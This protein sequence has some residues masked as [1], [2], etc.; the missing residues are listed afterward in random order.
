MCGDYYCS[1]NETTETCG[2][3]C[4]DKDRDHYAVDDPLCIS[5]DP[6]DPYS[7]QVDCNDN[8]SRIHPGA[9][10]YCNGIDNNCNGIVDDKPQSDYS[11]P[12]Y[13]YSDPFC[14]TNGEC[15]IVCLEGFADCDGLDE[16]GCE[17]Y[18]GDGSV[19]P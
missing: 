9:Y 19:C 13:Q 15:S 6:T 1:H 14:N 4:C 12:T 17:V 5:T 18:V 11:C 16:T 8:D 7:G 3:D 10:E 2:Q